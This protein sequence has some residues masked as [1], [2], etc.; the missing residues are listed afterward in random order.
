MYLTNLYSSRRE[1]LIATSGEIA[2]VVV[3]GVLPCNELVLDREVGFLRCRAVTLC[4][5]H[6]SSAYCSVFRHSVSAISSC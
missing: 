1:D 4:L 6:L 3:T 5:K 2:A